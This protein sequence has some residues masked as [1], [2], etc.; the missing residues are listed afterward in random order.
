ME[1]SDLAL[2]QTVA[3]VRSIGAVERHPR[4]EPD[5]T[6]AAGRREGERE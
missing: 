5:V 3:A 6:E 1:L 2:F 4:G